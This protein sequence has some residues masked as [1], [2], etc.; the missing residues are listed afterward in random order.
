MGE[1][2]AH[3]ENVMV[4]SICSDSLLCTESQDC[5]EHVWSCDIRPHQATG[6]EN[7]ADIGN[8]KLS[9]YIWF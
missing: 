1:N 8:N 6:G 7:K 2:G 9:D 4:T 5:N 3:T